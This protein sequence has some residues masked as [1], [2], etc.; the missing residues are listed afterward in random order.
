MNNTNNNELKLPSASSS[1]AK[2]D[3]RTDKSG[4]EKE[5]P[6]QVLDHC[7]NVDVNDDS[8]VI[9]QRKNTE[10]I[11]SQVGNSVYTSGV[12]TV[13][14]GLSGQISSC[15]S[16]NTQEMMD[17]KK[18][19][20][21]KELYELSKRKT[22]E[23]E[24]SSPKRRK[25]KSESALSEQGEAIIESNENEKG[26]CNRKTENV[27]VESSLNYGNDNDRTTTKQVNATAKDYIPSEYGSF[28]KISCI[29]TFTKSSVSTTEKIESKS[30]DTPNSKGG[31]THQDSK[32]K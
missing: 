2:N 8:I 30:T 7:Q 4:H 6:T 1:Y 28:P 16:K 18:Y 14:K 11:P 31:I 20:E 26:D 32:E 13:S 27:T 17:S 23:C 5:Q 10:Y 3:E 29:S 19:K 9:E 21:F 25:A 15:S 22:N 12:N 24:S